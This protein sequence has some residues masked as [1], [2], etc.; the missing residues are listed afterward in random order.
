M[1][2]RLHPFRGL[3][4]PREVW[5]WGMFD[6]ANQSFTLLITTVFFGIYFKDFIVADPARGEALWGRSFSIAALIVVVLSPVAGAIADHTA[7]KKRWLMSLAAACIGLTASFV[8]LGPGDVALA[9]TLYIAANVCFMLGE[10]FLGAFLPEVA[11]RETMGRVSATGWTMGYIGALICLPLALLLPGVAQGTERGFRLVFIFAAVWFLLNAIPTSLYLRERGRIAPPE[12]GPAIVAGFRRLAQTA[13][14]LR[15]YRALATFLAVFVV[16]SCGVQ[17][18]I[19]FSAVIAKDYLPDQKQLILFIW[20]L[21]AVSGAGSFVT[22]AVQDRVGHRRVISIALAVWLVT[23]L[24]AA[25]LPKGGA[26]PTWAFWLVGVGVGL[27]LGT[28]GSASRALVGTMTPAHKAAEFF[29]FWGIAYKLAGAIGPWSFGEISAAAGRSAALLVI[30]GFFALGLAG[31]WFVD[32][33]R[34]RRAAEEAERLAG[35]DAL[36]ARDRAALP[37]PGPGVGVEAVDR[38]GL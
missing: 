7:R 6:L 10:N 23:A 22:A 33:G 4:N 13:R 21:A 1:L 12:P 34:G 3:P 11:T 30:A 5:A 37:R 2:R 38:S 8:V 17:V 28:I 15:H 31:L 24:G 32:V 14:E 27:G 25:T 26:G 19:V 36:D 9:M 18:I 20:A 16:Y 29:A 35:P